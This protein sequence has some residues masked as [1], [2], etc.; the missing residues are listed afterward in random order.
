MNALNPARAELLETFA[1]DTAMVKGV[2]SQVFDAAGRAYLDFLAQYGALPF[3]HNPPEIWAALRGA[4][5]DQV[6]VM[7]QPLRSIVAE[8]LA[9]RLAQVTPG[10]LG[11]VTFTNSGAETVE[12]AMAAPHEPVR[13]PS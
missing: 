9:K 5:Q 10:D 3:G 7:M 8:R 11:I 1:L 2:G 4:E 13:W 6:P 12:A